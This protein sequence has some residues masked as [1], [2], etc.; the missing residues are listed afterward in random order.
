MPRDLPLPPGAHLVSTRTLPSGFNVVE[1]T[2][3]LSVSDSLLFAIAH[4]QSAGYTV[5]RGIRSSS[6]TN[7]PFTKAGR[8]GAIRL[9][10]VNPCTTSWQVLA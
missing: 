9:I 6:Q 5:G 2:S 4:L 1:F 3:P 7:L 8:P 10:A